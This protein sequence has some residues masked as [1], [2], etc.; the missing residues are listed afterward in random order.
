M[1]GVCPDC[2]G[3]ES[4][5]GAC[6][7]CEAVAAFDLAHDQA[8]REERKSKLLRDALELPL[9]FHS[10]GP[11]DEAKRSR[12]RTITGGDDATTRAMCDHIRKVLEPRS[13]P[14]LPP[15]ERFSLD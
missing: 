2:G 11:W 10:A 8:L 7:R 6:R 14:T 9:L 5:Y 15:P 4:D 1:S 13:T 12:W 3:Y